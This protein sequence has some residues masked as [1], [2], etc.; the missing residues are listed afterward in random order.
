MKK[1]LI[2][3]LGIIT[4]CLVT[5]VTL[6]VISRVHLGVGQITV[7]EQ[8]TEFTLAKKFEV[9]QVLGDGAL[10]R[11]GDDEYSISV[12]TG[13]IVYILND[14]GNLFYDDQ[15]IEVPD[16]KKVIQIGTYR[17]ETQMG[18]KVVPVLKLLN[19]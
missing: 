8:Q 2:F 16:G 7:S 18:E 15:V 1:W 3:L 11:C 4:G 5:F 19:Q 12:F 14:D 10:A 13:P 17:Y 9:F 6:L